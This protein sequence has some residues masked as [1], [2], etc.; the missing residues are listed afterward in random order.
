MLNACSFHLIDCNEEVDCD[1][2]NVFVDASGSGFGCFIENV[3]D[4][5]VIGTWSEPE[6]SSSSTW[7]EL[8]AVR[9]SVFSHTDTLQGKTLIVNSDNKNVC[10]I[11]N[12]GSRK[13]YLQVK[14]LSLVEQCK[15][16]NMYLIPKWIPRNEN[17]QADFLSRNYVMI[18]L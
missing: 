13:I 15:Q 4:S 18:G 3:T 11:I 2:A 5:E 7:R 6:S 1:V 16:H 10:N 9:R 14:A 8:E 17:E 12:I